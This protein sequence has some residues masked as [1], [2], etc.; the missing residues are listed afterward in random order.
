MNASKVT[1]EKALYIY[2]ISRNIPFD[3]GHVITE[4]ILECT[5][6]S[7]NIALGF[8]SL[9]TELCMLSQVLMARNEEK[10]PHPYPISVKSTKTR[11]LKSVRGESDKEGEADEENEDAETEDEEEEANEM[12]PLGHQSKL[13]L[14]S[15][16]NMFHDHN[17][18]LHERLDKQD[19]W[20]RKMYETLAT[21]TSSL[22]HRQDMLWESVASLEGSKRDLL[23]HSAMQE[24]H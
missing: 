6:R 23:A 24:S 5:K 18:A 19:E 1:K 16:G 13:I 21:T 7:V 20:H 17:Q 9:I 14:Q 2:A 15:V 3:I 11:P 12:P 10:T 22:A 4:Y 8:P